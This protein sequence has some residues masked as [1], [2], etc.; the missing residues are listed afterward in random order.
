MAENDFSTSSA[1]DESNPGASILRPLMPEKFFQPKPAS[2]IS[3]LSLYFWITHP[4]AFWSG[5]Q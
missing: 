2:M 4:E 1:W 5:E 3:N